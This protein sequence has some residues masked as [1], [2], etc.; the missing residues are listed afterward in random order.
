MSINLLLPLH[1]YLPPPPSL[2]STPLNYLPL[3]EPPHLS[4]LSS[5]TSHFSF[6][7]SHLS[8]LISHLS[9]LISHLSSLTSHLS[10]LSS[11][12]SHVSSLSSLTSH[13]S[14]LR[15]FRDSIEHSAQG[16]M[17]PGPFTHLL[18]NMGINLPTHAHTTTSTTSQTDDPH[19]QYHQ[20]TP[21][22]NRKAKTRTT[23]PLSAPSAR[24]R[25]PH[26]ANATGAGGSG[27]SGISGHNQLKRFKIRLSTGSGPSDPPSLSNYNI[28]PA[29]SDSFPSL[30]QYASRQVR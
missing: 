30:A 19:H 22:N 11:L 28:Y 5:L 23:R 16:H 15:Q 21:A 27:S 7:I 24:S 8:F 1:S 25:S 18:R 20:S 29:L 17:V 4:Y 6:L 14:S 2:F 10:Y 12:T 13:L 3:S 9:P 26:K